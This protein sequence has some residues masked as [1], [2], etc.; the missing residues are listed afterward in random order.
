MLFNVMM[1][2]G[3]GDNKSDTGF[4]DL[5]DPTTQAEP[6]SDNEPDNPNEPDSP[7]EP[8]NPN[9]PGN[10]NEPDNPNEPGDSSEPGNPNEPDNPNE[11]GNQ[12]DT[13]GGGQ[14][15]G[16]PAIDDDGD[17]ISEDNGDCDDT[18]GQ[19][20]PG[21]TDFPGDGIDQDCSGADATLTP[22]GLLNGNMDSESGGYPTDWM[23]IGGSWGWQEHDSNIFID[24]VDTGGF[25]GAHSPMGGAVKLWGAGA[26]NPS[27][28]GEAIVYQE[29]STDANW[30][31]AG[32]VFW[33]RA[34]GLHHNVDPLTGNASAY[35]VIRCLDAA[36]AIQG[37]AVTQSINS[38]TQVE[39]W[40]N[41]ATWVQCNS[42]TETV[43][44][45]LMFHQTDF[46]VDQG[47]VFFDDVDFNEVQ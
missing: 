28:P 8:D 47:T 13:G 15:T 41:L 27:N 10:P 18:N 11:P 16:D 30:S 23:N 26:A 38:Q 22:V 46:I 2:I 45:M 3:C 6:S 12:N 17:G 44:V 40:R 31:P 42:M 7:N 14:N 25:F 20:Y 43:Q 39:S 5:Y 34:W 19:V 29:F 21:A 37:D 1:L 9:E 35:G 33:L 32:K 36:G 4:F 24:G